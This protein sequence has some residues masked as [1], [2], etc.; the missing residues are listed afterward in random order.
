METIETKLTKQTEYAGFWLRF[1]AYIIDSLVVKTISSIIAILIV[2]I[3]AFIA[4][5]MDNISNS[6]DILTNSNL[7]KISLIIGSVSI[8]SLFNIAACWLY[9][10]LFESSKNGGTLG[11]MAV[12]IK[13]TDLNG[14]RISFTRATG[15]YF[16]RI[17]TNLTLLIGYI[18][19]GFTDRKQA[20]HDMIASCLVVKK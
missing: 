5:G 13:V 4:I 10:A 11:K 14:D 2:V 12:G 6:I 19:A 3:I 15:R 17:I 20:L 18:M 7:L 9:Y 16:G 8:L 1:A